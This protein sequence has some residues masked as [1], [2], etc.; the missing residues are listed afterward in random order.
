MKI[1]I[2]ETIKGVEGSGD[3]RKISTWYPGTILDDTKKAIPDDILAE[4]K[5]KTGRAVV[6]G[7]LTAQP[8]DSGKGAPQVEKVKIFVV[9]SANYTTFENISKVRSASIAE[10]VSYLVSKGVKI[11]AA[12]KTKL[13]EQAIEVFEKNG[14]SKP[15]NSGPN[16]G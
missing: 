15:D 10:L 2:K 14:S 8:A 6:V 5:A 13:L 7:E 3:N 11:E 16:K 12:D 9:D 1:E 4:V